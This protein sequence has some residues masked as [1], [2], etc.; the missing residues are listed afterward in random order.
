VDRAHRQ[1][2]RALEISSDPERSWVSRWA[3]AL[4]VFDAAHHARIAAL[5][6]SLSASGVSVAGA[7]FH[8]SG[9]DAAVRSAEAAARAL[10]L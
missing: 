10:D 1:L 3:R 2:Q 8:G 7:G 5:E 9:I 4:P 6:A